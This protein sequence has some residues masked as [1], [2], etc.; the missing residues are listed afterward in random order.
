MCFAITMTGMKKM[1]GNN[2]I[3]IIHIDPGFKINYF[4][5]SPGSFIQSIL[6]L[7]EAINLLK[8]QKIDL[9][10]SEPHNKAILSPEDSAGL[11]SPLKT[12][13]SKPN[14][15]LKDRP[16]PRPHKA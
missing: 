5:K 3:K 10:I 6:S 16:S 7:R 15:E 9:I 14:L 12:E 8:T 1:E 2:P 4:I 11:F 13:N